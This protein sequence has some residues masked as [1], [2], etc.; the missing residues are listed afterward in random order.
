MQVHPNVATQYMGTT[1]ALEMQLPHVLQ[2]V[3]QA[4]VP[5][6]Q[7]DIVPLVKSMSVVR[8]ARKVVKKENDVTRDAR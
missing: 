8:V 4:H 7:Q 2:V 5:S 6:M 3:V 1:N